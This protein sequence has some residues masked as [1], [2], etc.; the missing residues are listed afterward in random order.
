[1]REEEEAGEEETAACAGIGC[2]C[3]RNLKKQQGP[4]VWRELLKAETGS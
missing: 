2:H 3:S 4:G 1:M